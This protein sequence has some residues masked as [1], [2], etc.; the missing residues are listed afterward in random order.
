MVRPI[1][2]IIFAVGMTILTFKGIVPPEAFVGLSTLAIT[3]WF[4]SRDEEKKNVQ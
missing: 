3:F 1:I 4:K 2:S